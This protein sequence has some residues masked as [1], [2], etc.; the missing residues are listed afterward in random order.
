[1]EI[2]LIDSESHHHA[3]KIVGS[4]LKTISSNN[5]TTHKFSESHDHPAPFSYLILRALNPNPT[6]GKTSGPKGFSGEH[7]CLSDSP[8][9]SI[10]LR[11]DAGS[12]HNAG[13]TRTDSRDVIPPSI[14][15]SQ[16]APS[17]PAPFSYQTE[18]LRIT[19]S[20]RDNRARGWER[21]ESD[22]C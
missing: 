5:R 2:R 4:P 13:R 21:W 18:K 6:R 12:H 14:A 15:P 10:G 8:P 3:G 19:A 17:S 7:G 16:S 1:M 11:D 20:C 9:R 22:C